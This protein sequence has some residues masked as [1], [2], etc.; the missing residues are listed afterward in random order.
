MSQWNACLIAKSEDGASRL[1]IDYNPTKEGVVGQVLL[2]DGQSQRIEVVAAMFVKFLA[3]LLTL[4]YHAYGL[5]VLQVLI[6]LLET[7]ENKELE[8]ESD[9]VTVIQKGIYR[10]QAEVSQKMQQVEDER[11]QLDILPLDNGFYEWSDLIERIQ[12]KWK[13]KHM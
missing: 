2:Y 5:Y 4:D 3:V 8:L 11:K 6:A 9:V 1:Y 10:L 7:D 12:E 13:F